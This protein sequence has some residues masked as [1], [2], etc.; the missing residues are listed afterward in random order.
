MLHNMS[1]SHIQEIFIHAV[2][3]MNKFA[4]SIINHKSRIG[5]HYYP[6]TVHY[7]ENDLQTWL[8]ELA[9]LNASWIVLQS[10]ADRAIPEQFIT[11][12]IKSG[13]EPIIHF[14]L[15]LAE[16]PD[17]ESIAP[18]LR[19][20]ARW[21]VRGVIFF[22]RPNSRT[23][24]PS[25]GWAQQGLVERFLDI[26]LPLANC[27]IQLNLNP[28]FPPLEP[29]GSYWDTAFLRSALV[30]LQKRGQNQLLQNLVI[31]AYAWTRH[32]CLNWGAGGPQRWP[33]TRPYFT[34]PNAQDQR[35]F[36]IFDWYLAI[37]Q[38][39]LLKSC[40]IIL[41]GVG[42]PADPLVLQ[43]KFFSQ[44]EHAAINLAIAQLFAGEKVPDPFNPEELLEPI[45]DTVIASNYWCLT[46][47]PSSPFYNQ[48]WFQEGEQR[49]KVVS[50]F[51]EWNNKDSTTTTGMS[52]NSVSTSSLE[53][54][55]SAPSEWSNP[56]SEDSPNP[57]SQE[58][59]TDRLPA[60]EETASDTPSPSPS[61]TLESEPSQTLHPIDHYLLLPTYEWGIADWHLEVIRP[62]VK[63]Y[64]PTI[65][66][67]LK[68]AYFA[69]RVTVVGNT[70][71]FPDEEL[72]ALR[73]AGCQVERISGDGTTIATLLAE[74]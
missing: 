38:A 69:S 64:Q 58:E 5:F 34:P 4:T 24:W 43:N 42:A 13:I 68:E 74:R 33:E 62:F 50:L 65:G 57:S 51:K 19:A 70:Q 53:E 41:L 9:S 36:R 11:T 27:A 54:P 2:G 56:P 72:A 1:I 6:D 14:N 37:T 32:A 12:L 10:E 21:G 30:S 44:E 49:L 59:S 66:F 71:T 52:D 63:K 48:G 40:P 29:G 3:T 22:D 18:I 46:A 20:Y 55:P 60:E 26:F 16:P 15:S 73:A 23:S 61:Q 39:V 47:D 8:P 25:C 28:I 45:P 7:R 17:P 35:G 31:S 67:S